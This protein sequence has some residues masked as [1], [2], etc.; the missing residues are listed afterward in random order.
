MT[1]SLEAA[2]HYESI[3]L[4]IVPV[5]GLPSSRTCGRRRPV[6]RVRADPEAAFAIFEERGDRPA[7]QPSSSP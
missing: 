6:G 2:G 5:I 4:A 3:A 7:A 1:S